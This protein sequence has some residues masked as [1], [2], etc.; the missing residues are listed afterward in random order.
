MITVL[1]CVIIEWFFGFKK[2]W[3]H[4]YNVRHKSFWK[5]AHTA[6]KMTPDLSIGY[7]IITAEIWS[8]EV[9]LQLH[10]LNKIEIHSAI[11]FALPEE[12]Y[13]FG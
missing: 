7:N 9:E 13:A 4:D 12:R 1:N 5:Y 8:I 10:I 11:S 2:N 6:I 3:K